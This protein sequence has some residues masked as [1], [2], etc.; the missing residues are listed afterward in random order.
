M[1]P[2]RQG[3]KREERTI[4][5]E[6][7]PPGDA[8]DEEAANNRT[9]KRGGGRSTRPQPERAAL[10]YTS[11]IRGDERERARNEQRSGG[12]LEYPE[13]DEQ[14][15]ARREAAKH[16]SHAEAE[17]AQE[18]HAL[19]PVEIIERAGENEEGAQSQ[20]VGVVDVRLPLQDSEEAARQIA[21]D[22]GQ[23][24]VDYGRVEEHDARPEHGRN[25][26]PTLHGHDPPTS[27]RNRGIRRSVPRLQL[28][29]RRAPARLHPDCA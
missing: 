9:E 8:V 27:L 24:D 6:G 16:R 23:R 29:H 2:R 3:R 17:Q 18:E 11:E 21:T 20:E 12:T 5:E 25:Q 13:E 26:D 22:P 4:E 14:L 15:H 19:A 1:P 7:G 28:R 10:L